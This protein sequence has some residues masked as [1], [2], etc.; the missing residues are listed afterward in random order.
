MSDDALIYEFSG[1]RLDPARRQLTHGGKPVAMFPRCFDALLLLIEHRG[2]LLDKEFLLQALWP[3]VVVDENSL[4]KVISDMRRALGEGPQDSGLHRHRS[5]SRL[6]VRRGCG[7][8][9]A[10]TGSEASSERWPNEEIRSLAVLPFKFLN[11]VAGDETLCIGLADALITRLGQLRRTLVRPTSSIARFAGTSLAPAAAGRE[12]GV[13]AVIAGRSG[14]PAPRCA[15]ACSW[16]RCGRCG[17]LGR[18][19]RCPVGGRAANSR[20]RSPSACRHRAHAGA[21][22][23]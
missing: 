12:L 2:E 13:D 20:I 19:V 10:S 16:C 5:A 7:S 15:S 1:R 21:G 22:A 8:P 23:R 17:V 9:C 6:S 18:E 14:A 3:D 4:A 11:P